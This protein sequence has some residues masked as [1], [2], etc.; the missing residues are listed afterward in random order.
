MQFIYREAIRIGGMMVVV[1]VCIVGCS[2]G[3]FHNLY[4]CEAVRLER[5]HRGAR[6]HP[7][8]QDPLGA[9]CRRVHAPLRNQAHME[10]Q[11]ERRRQDDP[12]AVAA[13]RSP[14]FPGRTIYASFGPA[15]CF[16]C[17][18]AERA[19]QIALRLPRAVV[20]AGSSVRASTQAIPRLLISHAPTFTSEAADHIL[21]QY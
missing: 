13:A 20:G 2:S 21:H 19:F 5:C 10:A 12:D 4:F 17:V 11:G 18:A 9:E 1:F 6:E 16:L 7:R 8:R 3:A 15:H 14:A